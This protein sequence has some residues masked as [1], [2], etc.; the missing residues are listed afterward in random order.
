FRTAEYQAPV[1]A[2]LAPPVNESEAGGLAAGVG[3]PVV[4]APAVA[5]SGQ[6]FDVLKQPARER[7]SDEKKGATQA[8]LD[9]FRSKSRGGKVTGILPVNVDFPAF[10][11]SIYLVSEL[12]SENQSPSAAFSFQRDKKGGA[13]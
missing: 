6:D 10:G 5:Q 9:R 7:S 8:L 12:T 11:P 2:A 1:S 13:R 4:N 3:G